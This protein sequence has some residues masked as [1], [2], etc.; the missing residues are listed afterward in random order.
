MSMLFWAVTP[1]G[2][3][4][5]DGDSTFIRNAGMYPEVQTASQ[6]RK[7][8]HA[9]VLV[10]LFSSCMVTMGKFVGNLLESVAFW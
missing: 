9:E 1:F 8:R 2:L 6:P 7:N 3:T 5:Q 10:V 4:A